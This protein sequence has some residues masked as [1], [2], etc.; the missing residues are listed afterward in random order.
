MKWLVKGLILET[1]QKREIIEADSANEAQM[2][3]AKLGITHILEISPIFEKEC[4]QKI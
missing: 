3:A 4:E 1:H 2:K